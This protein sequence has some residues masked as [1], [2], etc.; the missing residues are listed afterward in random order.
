MEHNDQRELSN[1]LAI[2]LEPRVLCDQNFNQKVCQGLI[3]VN[4]VYL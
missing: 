2:P 1:K 4:Q 3:L